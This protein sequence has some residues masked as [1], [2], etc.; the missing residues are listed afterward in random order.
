MLLDLTERNPWARGARGARA[1]RIAEPNELY[2]TLEDGDR[3]AWI[4]D[5][6]SSRHLVNDAALLLNAKRCSRKIAMENGNEL[7]L[8]QAGSV[9]LKMNASGMV[10]TVNFTDVYLAPQLACTVLSLGKLEQKGFGLVDEDAAANNA[11]G[12]NGDVEIDDED[13]GAAGDDRNASIVVADQ[14]LGPRIMDHVAA[15]VQ[16]FLLQT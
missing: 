16:K 8:I 5:G 3:S 13:I 15:L 1:G 12:I 7:E 11:V 9:R 2:N 10:K 14:A 4:L 6:G